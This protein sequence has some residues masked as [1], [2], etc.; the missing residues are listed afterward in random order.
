MSA[1]RLMRPVSQSADYGG[2]VLVTDKVATFSAR[3]VGVRKNF[4]V[5][6]VD[7][8]PVGEVTPDDVIDLLADRNQLRG[9]PP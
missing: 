3:I 5:T 8:R 2:S 7:G 9:A 1:A 6:A 4:L